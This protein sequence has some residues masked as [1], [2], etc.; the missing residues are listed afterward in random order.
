M[1]L[2][3]LEP[4]ANHTLCEV[5]THRLREAITSGVLPPGAPLVERE[6]AQ[7]LQIS[8][9]PVREAIHRLAEEGL[10]KK[11]SR[12]GAFVYR[13]SRKEIEEISSLRLVL[14]KLAVERVIARWNPEHE[15]CLEEIVDAVRRAALCR[16]RDAVF[17]Q[18]MR[19]H[20]ALWEMADHGIL[21][22]VLSSLRTRLNRY[23]YE[24][25]RTLPASCLEARA[26][27][28]EGL[29]EALKSG[30]VARAQEAMARQI[31][32]R[33]DGTAAARTAQALLANRA[34]VGAPS[35][36]GSTTVENG[37]FTL[38]GS[39]TD[40]WDQED[41]FQFAYQ[42]VEGDG[43]ISA[44]LL[45]SEGGHETW[46]KAGLMIRDSDAAGSRNALL[47]M[48]SGENLE[49]QWRATDDQNTVI[50]RDIAPRRFPLFLRIQRASHEIAGFASEDGQ[51]WRPLTVAPT[52]PMRETALFGLAVTSHQDGEITTARFDQVAV[53]PGIISPTGV[54]ACGGDQTVLLTWN[55]LPNAAGYRVF[56]GAP[57]AAADELTQLTTDPITQTTYADRSEGL[58]NGS[59]MLYAIVPILEGAGGE[60]FEG[61]TTVVLGM[62]V[63]AP[64]GYRACSPIEG[65]NTGSVSYDAAAEE[66]TIRASGGD[67]WDAGD[68]GYFVYQEREG[69]FRITAR[70]LTQ[71][72]NT[73]GWAKAGLTLRESLDP[74]AR[75]AFIYVTPDNGLV[76]Q[77][78]AQTHGK[79]AL[80]QAL[81]ADTLKV[82]IVLRL[83]RK[84]S[85]ITAELSQDDGATFKLAA[86]L[87]TF[88]RDLPRRLYVGL[89]ATAHNSSQITEAKFNGLEV[90]KL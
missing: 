68:Q 2:A 44:R 51:L 81:D 63:A 82:P 31:L 41:Q 57:D 72:S 70:A 30:D 11:V 33:E 3:S 13:P 39:G 52:I 47:Y 37:V 21:L 78:R 5:A 20:V 60:T 85:E 18:E 36:P 73:N 50:Q 56:R 22:E 35:A 48:S 34:D 32:S 58:V 9:V 90:Q 53:R 19:F 69:D 23:L 27:G 59:P 64:P 86:D 55:P 40:I 87:F 46:S 16:D 14:E 4:I 76:F 15:A 49:F 7:S 25:T 65:A 61:A 17:E 77:W 6:L 66:I 8:R 24:S 45:S 89:A 71:P 74:G 1:R 84:G 28:L 29:F 67:M 80:S 62:P 75:T 43:S 83:T 54:Q 10:V 79:T 88:D 38:Q 12:R 42:P 26:D